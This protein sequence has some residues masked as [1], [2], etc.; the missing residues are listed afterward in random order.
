MCLITCYVITLKGRDLGITLENE[1]KPC[2]IPK[3]PFASIVY[4][5]RSLLSLLLFRHSA[6]PQDIQRYFL[7]T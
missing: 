7:M 6:L 4:F 3:F 1:M 2:Y 5:V